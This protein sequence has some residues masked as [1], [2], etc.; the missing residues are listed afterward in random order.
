MLCSLLFVYFITIFVLR[1]FENLS[2]YSCLCF[3][4]CIHEFIQY[5]YSPIQTLVH[6]FQYFMTS[7]SVY[8]VLPQ[9]DILRHTM[10][11]SR[12]SFWLTRKQS[13][14]IHWNLQLRVGWKRSYKSHDTRKKLAF[15]KSCFLVAF[16][17]G[18]SC[19][20]SYPTIPAKNQIFESSKE[21]QVNL[22]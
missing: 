5:T 14:N 16:Q 10:K 1:F 6:I 7:Y 3:K 17:G 21:G 12:K 15:E 4:S 11:L 13:T 2:R 20:L 18:L 8:T 22:N 19:D 9:C